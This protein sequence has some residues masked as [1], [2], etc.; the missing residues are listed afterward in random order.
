MVST[1]LYEDNYR[2]DYLTPI[3][4]WRDFDPTKDPLEYS[5]A[6]NE[7]DGKFIRRSI[8]FTALSDEYGEVRACAKIVMPAQQRNKQKFVLF[9]PEIDSKNDYEP[10]MIDMA[11]RDYTV[12][13]VDLYGEGVNSTRYLGN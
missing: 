4:I 10:N 7:N 8:Y 1:G 9:I 11:S 13:R 5:I 12:A 3:Q 2:S 6:S